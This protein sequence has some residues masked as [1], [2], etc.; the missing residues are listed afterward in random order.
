MYHSGMP[1]RL[2]CNESEKALSKHCIIIKTPDLGFFYRSPK[3]SY[4]DTDSY[5][6][7]KAEELYSVTL[8]QP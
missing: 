5:L 2:A 6:S 4:E 7:M 1:M 8:H 3:H